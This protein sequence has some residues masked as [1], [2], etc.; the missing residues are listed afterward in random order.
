MTP[1]SNPGSQ[2][3]M[4]IPVIINNR[5]LFT[6]P[7]AMVEK[8]KTYDNAGDIIIVDNGSTYEPLVEW[9]GSKP[10][11]IV[12][13]KNLGH[14]GPWLSGLVNKISSKYYVVSDPDLGLDQTPQDTLIYMFEKMNRLKLEKIGLGLDWKSTGENS[15]F[16][17]HLLKYEGNRWSNSRIQDDVYLDIPVDTT[18]ALYRNRKHF[19]GGGS[20][21]YPYIA[22]H[23]PWYFTEVERE[24][25]EEFMYYLN[26][27]TES[28]SSRGFLNIKADR[29]VLKRLFDKLSI[30]LGK[31][32]R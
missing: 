6:W 15:P 2:Y 4:K 21:G 12:F 23:Y 10:C 13:C 14:K 11:D 26:H 1:P 7:K 17:E 22:K 28:S 25:N 16:Y 18:F 27:A 20:T 3:M 29:P 31:V 32:S 9:Y 19:I 5:N 8:I 24:M 30:K